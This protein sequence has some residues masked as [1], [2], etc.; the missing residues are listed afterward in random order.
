M[1]A[2]VLLTST[3][4]L[5]CLTAGPAAARDAPFCPP[6]Q[7]PSFQFGFAA[8]KAQIGEAMGDPTECEHSNPENGDTLQAT[9]TGL[10]FYRR[11]TNTPTFTDGF[12]HWGL[13][14]AGLVFW[15]GDSVD[16]PGAATASAPPQSAPRPSTPAPAAPSGPPR[17]AP[18]TLS[19]RGQTATEAVTLPWPVSVATFTHDGQRNFI[20]RS[21][22]GG[23]PTLQVNKIGRY[24]GQRP[25]TGS[26]PVTFDIQAD[27]MWAIRIE[28]IGLGGTPAVNGSGD[29]VSALFTPPPTGAWAISHNG[30]RNFIVRLHCAGGSSLVQNVIGPVQGSRGSCVVPDPLSP[31]RRGMTDIHT[32][33]YVLN[34]SAAG[35]LGPSVR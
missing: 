13:T 8:L 6:G 29:T 11:S 35:A 19:G 28:P 22:A 21:Y 33:T 4:T 34:G 5:L 26:A 23:E 2:F 15:T 25:V 30:S 20:V 9:T 27:G 18:V 1:R 3:L 24:Q 10:S 12:R 7:A 32:I 16:P 14:S 17:G 31:R